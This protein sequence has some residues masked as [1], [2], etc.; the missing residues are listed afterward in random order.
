M[1]NFPDTGNDLSNLFLH[2]NSVA[3]PKKFIPIALLILNLIRIPIFLSLNGKLRSFKNAHSEDTLLT[4]LYLPYRL[5][6]DFLLW[7][8]LLPS[9]LLPNSR[10]KRTQ[11]LKRLIF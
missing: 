1:V 5:A 4:V 10:T 9:P 11:V 7:I 2:L 8:K 3:D 6:G